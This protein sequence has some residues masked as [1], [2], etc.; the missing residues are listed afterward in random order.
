VGVLCHASA[1][2]SIEENV[3][4]EKRSGDKRFAVSTSGG[5]VVISSGD[6]DI[7]YSVKTFVKRTK[8]DV[9]L[10]FVVLESDEG[11]GKTGVAAEPELER[12]V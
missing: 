6:T 4:D 9:N 1:F 11:K 7:R 3:I 8:F 12:D 2:I 10:D 5:F